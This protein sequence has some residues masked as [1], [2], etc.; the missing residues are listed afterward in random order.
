ML[1]EMSRHKIQTFALEFW[2]LVC[3]EYDANC[4]TIL[5]VGR[6]IWPLLLKIF[7]VGDL[8]PALYILQIGVRS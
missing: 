5:R 8:N 2:V 7:F 6:G 3:D 4:P 1:G